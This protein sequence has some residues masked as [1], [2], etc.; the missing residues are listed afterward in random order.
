M[1]ITRKVKN[2]SKRFLGFPF[3]GFPCDF[4]RFPFFSKDCRGSA[5]IRYPR[6][7]GGFPCRFQKGKEKK[8]R[9]LALFFLLRGIPCFFGHFS[10]DPSRHLQECPG[11]RA[12]KCPTECF[13]SVFGCLPQSAPKSAFWVRFGTFWAK[14]TPKST[15]KELFGALRGK[16]PKA[17][18]KHSVGHFP[19]WALGHFCKWQPGSQRF[20]LLFQGFQGFSRAKNPFFGVV[21][22]KGR[23]GPKAFHTQNPMRGSLAITIEKSRIAIVDRGGSRD[24]ALT[25]GTECIVMKFHGNVREHLALFVSKPHIFIFGSL[26]LFWT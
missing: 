13:L 16:Y 4:E 21:F 12:G 24:R 8:I 23:T 10:C 22:R 15:E 5:S 19:A 11:A 7:F 1:E 3:Q 17:L 20:S 6:F 18:K 2:D 26:T 9:V 14:K 25:G